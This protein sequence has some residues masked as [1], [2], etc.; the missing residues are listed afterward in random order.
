MKITKEL[1]ELVGIILGD[2]SINIYLSNKYSTYY[3]LKISFHSDDREYISYVSYLLYNVLGTKSILKKRKDEN[4][5]DLY[6]FKKEIIMHLLNLGL[7]SSP[8]WNRGIIPPYL[9]NKE[10]GKYVLRG[11]FDTDGSVVLTNNNG[12][13]YPRLEMKI[14]PSPMLKQFEYLLNLYNFRFKSYQIGKGKVRIQI[15]GRK[16]LIKWCDFIGFSNP[17]HSMKAHKIY[18]REKVEK[19]LI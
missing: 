7:K 1:A 4:T 10:F 18:K 2:G 17:K 9:L 11:Y 14:S 3:R 12:T 15:N 8:K 13:L 5:A 16:E 19:T 6:I